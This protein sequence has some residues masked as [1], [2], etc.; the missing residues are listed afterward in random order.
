MQNVKI[1]SEVG[2]LNAGYAEVGPSV[3][4]RGGIPPRVLRRICDYIDANLEESISLDQLAKLAGFSKYHFT[5]IFKQ[6]TGLPPHAYLLKRRADRACEL[7][8]DTNMPIAE[9]AIAAGFSNQ[10]HLT[11][12]FRDQ[13]RMTPRAFRWNLR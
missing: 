10:S 7:L 8:S 13:L 11:C 1:A 6:A 12:R 2:A 9:V 3:V 4:F 5:R